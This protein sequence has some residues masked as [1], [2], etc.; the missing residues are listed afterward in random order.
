M[1]ELHAKFQANVAREIEK[2]GLSQAEFGRRLGVSR[3]RVGQV[4]QGDRVARLDLVERVAE[5]L[6]VP[7]WKLLK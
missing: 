4:L 7:A 5:G 6:G 3:A 2:Q 1:S